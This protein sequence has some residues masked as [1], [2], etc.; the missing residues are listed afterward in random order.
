LFF[1]PFFSC[2]Y[3]QAFTQKLEKNA[4]IEYDWHYYVEISM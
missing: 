1:S 2:F 3:H 4:K